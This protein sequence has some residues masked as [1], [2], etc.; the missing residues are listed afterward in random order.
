MWHYLYIDD[1]NTAYFESKRFME[2]VSA[3]MS[4]SGDN[5]IAVFSRLDK[6]TG[7][8][9]YYFTP[10][11]KAVAVAHGASPHEKPSKQEAGG[12][13]IGDQTVIDR[14]F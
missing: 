6:Q 3:H 7:G 9:H 1:P 14:L 12:L 8:V 5:D 10:L 13:L 11:A 4:T 2:A